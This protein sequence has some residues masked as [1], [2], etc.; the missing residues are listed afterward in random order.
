[1]KL[2]WKSILLIILVLILIGIGIIF[3]NK[4]EYVPDTSDKGIATT[5]NQDI[6]LKKN[7]QKTMDNTNEQKTYTEAILHTSM[8]DISFEFSKDKPLTTAN[9]QK[10]AESGFYDGVKFHRVIKDFMI[11]TGD[12][13][14]KDDT[15]KAYWGTG[16]PGYKFQDELTGAEKY[17]IGTVAMAN[18]G[19]NTNG[20]QFFIMT[21]NMGLPPSYTVFGK[22]VAGIDV[23]MKI[24]E[25]ATDASDKP[26]SPVTINSVDLK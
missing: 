25:V 3:R 17:T 23:A 18:S 4:G 13:L 16:G 24:Q 10:L 11:Q 7:N 9:F 26:L 8:G 22:V 21:S 1:M 5:T 19:P 15:K 6:N 20:S 14:S 2:N 12:P